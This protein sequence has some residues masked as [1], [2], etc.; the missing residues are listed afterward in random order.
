MLFDEVM[1]G[2]CRL[3]HGDCR[4]VLPLLPPVDLVL[5]DPPYGIDIGSMDMG[6]GKKVAAF[7][8][9]E[10]DAEPP[11]AWLFGL[12]REKGEDLIVWGGNYFSLGPSGCWLSWDKMQEFSGADFELAYTT[13]RGPSKTFRLSRVQ[14]YGAVERVH[15]TQKPLSLMEW[16]IGKVPDAQT[17]SDPFM[18][19]G[20]TGVACIRLGKSF[21]GIERERKYFDIACERIA[22]AQAQVQL[23]P[24]ETKPAAVQEALI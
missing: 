11:P 14:A 5:T 15:P 9:F 8:A 3:I 18:G 12:L 6:K 2:N 16:C 17:V 21:V 19:S 10:W 4:E 1:I 23:F 13:L 22:R 24:P 7:E 20:T